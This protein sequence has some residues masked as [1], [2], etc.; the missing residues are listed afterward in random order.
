MYRFND[1]VEITQN[2]KNA[3]PGWAW[4]PVSHAPVAQVMVSPGAPPL[5]A[6]CP[7]RPGQGRRT[8]CTNPGASYL[9]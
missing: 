2:K 8:A 7:L 5:P 3:W 1:S 6:V 9:L 4:L